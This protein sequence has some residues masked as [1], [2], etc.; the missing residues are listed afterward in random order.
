MVAGMETLMDLVN[1]GKKNNHAA[2][3]TTEYDRLLGELGFEKLQYVPRVRRIREQGYIEISP[4]AIAKFLVFKGARGTTRWFMDTA[5]MKTVLSGSDFHMNELAESLPKLYRGA[6]DVQCLEN[7]TWNDVQY[8]EDF[9]YKFLL[10]L[11]EGVHSYKG[12][13]PLNV[14]K[15]LE[16]EKNRNFFDGFVIAS[17]REATVRIPDPLL[18]GYIKG[19]DGRFFIAQWGDDVHLDDII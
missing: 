8:L 9:T 5:K 19:Y 13:P 4:E 16:E 7:F 6:F 2:R 17:Y 11:E 1:E 12:I 14:L 18:L 10:W 15:R 3:M